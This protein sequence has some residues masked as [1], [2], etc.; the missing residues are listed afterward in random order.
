M[1]FPMGDAQVSQYIEGR[2][3]DESAPFSCEL[4]LRFFFELIFLHK[5][6]NFVSSDNHKTNY[7]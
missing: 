2:N 5:S 4:P 7:F 1:P 6:Q 3:I